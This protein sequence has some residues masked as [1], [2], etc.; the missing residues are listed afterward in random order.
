MYWKSIVPSSSSPSSSSYHPMSLEWSYTSST[1]WVCG[2]GNWYGNWYE[3]LFSDLWL[4][5]HLIELIYFGVNTFVFTASPLYPAVMCVCLVVVA[6][7]K[8]TFPNI[9]KTQIMLCCSI[10][11]CFKEAKPQEA[12]RHTTVKMILKQNNIIL[13]TTSSRVVT[14]DLQFHQVMWLN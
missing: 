7:Q 3:I 11:A 5:S 8:E 12:C 2:P 9:A 10:V 4:V 6:M 14:S 1:F 13:S